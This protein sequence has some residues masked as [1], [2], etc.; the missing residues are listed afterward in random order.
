[1]ELLSP[2]TWVV[3]KRTL[4][5]LRARP[6]YGRR[7]CPGNARELLLR[8]SLSCR[9]THPRHLLSRRRRRQG[10][11]RRPHR[12]RLS[13]QRIKRRRPLLYRRRRPKISQSRRPLNPPRPQQK[14]HRS[15]SRCR[16]H[17]AWL[18]KLNARTT[19]TKTPSSPSGR[20]RRWRQFAP[21]EDQR[22]PCRRP[23]QKKGC[24]RNLELPQQTRPDPAVKRQPLWLSR[25]RGRRS[26]KRARASAR[27]E[28][29]QPRSSKPRPFLRQ[30][31][32]CRHVTATTPLERPLA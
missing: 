24:G 12:G 4:P 9:P 30:Q 10:T 2:G 3:L 15:P 31:R 11:D 19:K 29:A 1:M 5:R 25:W 18:P 7:A 16:L 27:F 14:A 32:A 23:C 8:S 13:P 6:R 21:H 28:R 17:R 20:K 22:V 26:R